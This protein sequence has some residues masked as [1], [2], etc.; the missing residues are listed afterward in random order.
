MVEIEG[1]IREYARRDIA[2]PRQQRNEVDL[3]ETLDALI[4]RI[5]GASIEEIDRVISELQ[6][7]RDMLRKEG[8]RVNREIAS[9]GSLN[10]AAATVMKVI[11]DNLTQWK[12]APDKPNPHS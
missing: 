4:R 5:S 6:S 1:E 9:F 3:A 2:F 11:I 8:E 12:S 10:Y 7:V